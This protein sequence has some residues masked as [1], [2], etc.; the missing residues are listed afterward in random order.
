MSSFRKYKHDVMTKQRIVKHKMK[1]FHHMFDRALTLRLSKSEVFVGEARLLM[2]ISQND[3]LTQRELAKLGGTSAAS[4]GVSL[5]KLENKGYIT[6]VSDKNDSR[7]ILISLTEK[8]ENFIEKA[9]VIFQTLDKDTFDGFSDKELEVFDNFIDRLNT[10]LN[11][12]L[13]ENE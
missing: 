2:T 8:G 6:R 12:I 4:V 5:K 10:N 1:I 11:G 13:G 3:N 7:A 9:H